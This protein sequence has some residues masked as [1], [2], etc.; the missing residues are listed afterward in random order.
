MQILSYKSR[1]LALTAIII[2]LL[3]VIQLYQVQK[4]YWL[5]WFCW[6]ST[7]GKTTNHEVMQ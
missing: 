6:S 5:E 1:T 7:F 4:L 3:M 2:I